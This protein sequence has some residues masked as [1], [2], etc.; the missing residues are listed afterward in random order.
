MEV[1]SSLLAV[2]VVS[3]LAAISPGPDFFIVLKNSLSYS[4][5]A[6]FLTACG[7]ALALFFHL[8]YTVV[9]IGVLIAES[10]FI[11]ALMKYVGVAYLFY[12]G[13]SSLMASFKKPSSLDLDY[14]QS[15]QQIS[16]KTALLQGFLTNLL[17]LKAALFFISLF[18]QFIDANTPLLLRVE[19]AMTNWIV[20]LSWFLFLSYVVTAQKFRGKINQFRI[21]IDRMMGGALMLLGLKML[22]V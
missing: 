18:S 12:L 3:L 2:A 1:L 21:Y 8:F 9:G 16:S 5:R 19:F 14:T 4:R 6:G 11:Y 20:S 7:V 17:N 22:F 10:P 15:T 13:L